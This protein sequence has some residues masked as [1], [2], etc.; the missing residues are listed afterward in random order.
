MNTKNAYNYYQYNQEIR[1][2]HFPVTE[3]A[4]ERTHSAVEVFKTTH[5]RVCVVELTRTHKSAHVGFI[6]TY[7]PEGKN[8]YTNIYIYADTPTY[9]ILYAASAY[10]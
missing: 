2:Q 4:G 1:R 5:V 3:T 8:M 6:M 9:S 10:L 7:V